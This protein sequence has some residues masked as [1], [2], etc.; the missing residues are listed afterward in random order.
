MRSIHPNGHNGSDWVCLFLDQVTHDGAEV[1]ELRFEEYN[2]CHLAKKPGYKRARPSDHERY[3]PTG[4]SA[5]GSSSAPSADR[6]DPSS[7]STDDRPFKHPK[8]P[9]DD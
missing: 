6:A 4:G 3:A 9:W 1:Y 5:G 7:S 8:L 2:R